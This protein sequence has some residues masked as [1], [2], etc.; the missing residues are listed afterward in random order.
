M[1]KPIRKLS[2]ED[3]V[4]FYFAA[5]RIPEGGS[6]RHDDADSHVVAE[7][8]S[9]FPETRYLTARC[10]SRKIWQKAA[11]ISELQC[12]IQE[13]SNRRFGLPLPAGKTTAGTAWGRSR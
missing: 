13:Q 5:I 3:G 8:G 1:E 9:G 10:L 12:W 2:E 11:T 7:C 4:P 6:R